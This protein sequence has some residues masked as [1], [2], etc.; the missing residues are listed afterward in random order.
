MSRLKSNNYDLCVCTHS[1]DRTLTNQLT[2]SNRWEIVMKNKDAT[3]TN[4]KWQRYNTGTKNRT[5]F[6]RFHYSTHFKYPELI[7]Q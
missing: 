4:P 6:D 5:Y 2:I 1:A 3:A 7:A